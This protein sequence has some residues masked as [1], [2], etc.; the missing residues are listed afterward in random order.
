MGLREI[1]LKTLSRISLGVGISLLVSA[2]AT[3]LFVNFSHPVAV[4]QAAFGTSA[5]LFFLAMNRDGLGRRIAGRATLF[6]G[7]SLVTTL[8][9]VAG[10][11]AL[12]AAAVVSKKSWDQ[13]EGQLHTL[14]SDTTKTLATLPGEVTITAFFGPT[15]PQHAPLKEVLERY[16]AAAGDKLVVTFVDPFANPGLVK[17]KAI[18][19][20]GARVIITSGKNEARIAE[21]SE[22]ALT[23]GVLKVLR[24]AEKKVYVLTGH[25]EPALADA[26]YGGLKAVQKRLADEGLLARELSLVEKGAVPGD[27]ALVLLIA[28][29]RPLLPPELS[30]LQAWVEA[31][32][33]LFVALEPG[34][35]DE[36]VDAWLG[37]LGFAPDAALIVDPLSKVMGG[38]P[39]IPVVRSYGEHEI[40]REFGLVTVF[41]TARPIFAGGDAEPRPVV[42]AVTNESAWAERTLGGGEVA[43][44]DDEKKGALP[45]AAV[46]ARPGKGGEARVAVFGDADFLTNQ[47]VEVGGNADLFLNT[48]SWLASQE[49]RITIRTKVRESSRLL[50]TEADAAFINVFAMNGLPMLVLALGLSVWLVRRAR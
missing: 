39:A 18:K 26:A 40:T 14:S 32:G 44:D 35:R 8:V 42:L 10:L 36:A 5:V 48:A 7:V 11:A 28:P 34:W 43:Q 45:I 15:E 27:A 9:L 19:E 37:T 46:V 29:T 25:G 50:L 47:Y 13:T 33:R 24:S 21:L 22:E 30:A 20:G 6:Y 2:A 16:Q 41:P 1:S 31:G 23:N 49:S 12:N 38:G 3:L 17:E 4:G